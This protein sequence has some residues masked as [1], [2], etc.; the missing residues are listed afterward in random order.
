MKMLKLHKTLLS[1]AAG[2]VLAL[3]MATN[4]MAAPQ[5]QVDPPG[6]LAPFY[7]TTMNGFSS[8]RL[9]A[10]ATGLETGVGE[11]GYLSFNNFANAGPLG[12]LGDVQPFVSGL[13]GAPGTGYGLYLTFALKADYVG[14]GAGNGT[15]GS[16]YSLSQLDFTVYLDPRAV[17]ADVTT[18]TP[19]AVGTSTTV[20]GNGDDIVLGSGSLLSGVAGVSAQQGVFLNAITSY[21]NTA[22]GNA[23]FVDPV[24]FY[25][26]A[27]S[28]FNNTLQGFTTNCPAVDCEVA[29]SA[30]GIVDFNRVPEPNSLALLGALALGL[31]AVSRRSRKA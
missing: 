15:V 23:F 1:T 29:I 8:E 24:P 10:T 12:P 22:A 2:A 20:T 16:Q 17:L 3:G 19:A 28:G 11:F 7:A 25:S 27:F 30:A 5:F 13:G 4:S 26:L 14:G 6:A 9:Y 31:G 21:A 18:L